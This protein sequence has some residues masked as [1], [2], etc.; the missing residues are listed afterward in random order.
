MSSSGS[1]ADITDELQRFSGSLIKSTR[2][3][4]DKEPGLPTA[5]SVMRSARAKDSRRRSVVEAVRH[6][7][8]LSPAGADYYSMKN[9]RL[10]GTGVTP[11]ISVTADQALDVAL[12]L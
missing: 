3:D 5:A 2:C 11:D 8:R 4:P 1:V 9:G 12:G 10:E 6:S 7:R